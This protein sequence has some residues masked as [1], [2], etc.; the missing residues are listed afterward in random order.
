[1]EVVI[2]SGGG[3]DKRSGLSALDFS[4]TAISGSE[5]CY[6]TDIILRRLLAVVISRL[7]FFPSG[8][9]VSI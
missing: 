9:G 1:M 2:Q 3:A 8:G 4:E 6:K 5:L 7:L